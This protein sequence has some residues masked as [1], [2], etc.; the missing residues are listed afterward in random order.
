M[1]P[2]LDGIRVI[3]VGAVVLGPYA[4]QLLADLGADV[5]KVEPL[6]GDIARQA[7]PHGEGGGALFVNNNRN[8]RMLAIDLKAPEGRAAFA[9]LLKTADVLF[10]NMRID[11]ADRLGL[12]FE[13]AAAINPRIIHCAAVGF[14][15]RGPYR[16]RPAFDDIIQAAA[17][18]AG[19]GIAAGGEPRFVLT[20]LA[21]KIA[22]LHAVY[23]ILAALVA[24]ANGREGAI[25]VEVPMFEA[26][27]AF[28][29]NE[30]LAAAT[31]DREGAVGYPRILSPNR[32]PFRSADGWIA[33]L[34]YTDRQWRA[35]LAEIGREDVAEED[36][37]K[38]ARQRAA[39]ID[40]LYA[41]VA[42]SLAARTTADWIA[43]LSAR[44]VPCSEVKTLEGLL[45]DPHLS[46]LGFF[47]VPE[48]WPEGVVRSL[49]QAVLFDGFEPR[50]DTPPRGLG[51]DSRAIL[52][53]TG[54]P[55]SDID[56]LIATGVVKSAPD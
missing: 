49:P 2:L 3:E 23:G 33:V 6:E 45:T 22:A 51:E 40:T 44:D 4:S 31:F 48:T 41:L 29:L 10:H 36:W 20:I 13:T 30:H 5:I 53:E 27:T 25:K 32:R 54:M 56:A 28:L 47:D 16:D 21:D 37:F 52:R 14:G 7:F 19:L 8:K 43:A 50:P 42:E 24:R 9:A 15:Q 12:G 39:R 38:D 35:F 18:I 17:G 11:A 26:L 34:P 55:E 46:Q 1:L